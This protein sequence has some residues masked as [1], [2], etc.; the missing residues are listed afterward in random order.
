MSILEHLFWGCSRGVVVVAKGINLI[1]NK[2]N[3]INEQ[4]FF[5]FYIALQRGVSFL[6]KL[7]NSS[8]G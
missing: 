4:V 6:F 3:W 5:M 1:I 7:L 2:L 8:L